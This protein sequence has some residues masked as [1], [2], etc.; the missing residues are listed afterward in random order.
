MVWAKFREAQDLE[1]PLNDSGISSDEKAGDNIWSSLIQVPSYAPKGQF[2]FDILA[3][4][5]DLRGIHL[6]G[7]TPEGKPEQGSLVFSVK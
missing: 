1:Y 2:H 5:K 6:P 4:D 7:T 3:I